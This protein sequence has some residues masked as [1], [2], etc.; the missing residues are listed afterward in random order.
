MAPKTVSV[1]SQVINISGSWAIFSQSQLFN[2][3]G[4]HEKTAMDNM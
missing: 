3:A 2:S 4:C 1:K